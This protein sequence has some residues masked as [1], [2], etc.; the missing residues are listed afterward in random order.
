MG[1]YEVCVGSY[2]ETGRNGVLR[3]ALDTDTLSAEILAA[4]NGA[5]RPSWI[6]HNGKGI[7]YAVSE[8]VPEGSVLALRE[9]HDG[10][11]PL[12]ECPSGGA[13]PCHLCL[14]TS[15]RFLFVSNYTSGSLSMV[16]L[17]DMGAPQGVV[18][19]VQHAGRGT[20]PQRQADAHVH[21]SQLQGDI[22]YVCDLGQDAIFRYRVDREEKRLIA[23]GEPLRM[24]AGSG[25]RHLCFAPGRP[26]RLYAVGEL[27]ASLCYWVLGKTGWTLRQR[28]S[29][30]PDGVPEGNGTAGIHI[31]GDGRYLFVSNRGADCI[32][33]FCLAP[34]GTIRLLDVCAVGGRTPRD[35]VVLDNTLLVACQ[36]DSCLRMLRLNPAD[37]SLH[38]LDW[39]F[40]IDK[41]SCIQKVKD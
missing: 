35:F 18:D 29:T 6:V 9:E 23:W 28:I 15:E 21:F 31:S 36:N 38:A 25:V 5:T 30:L 20:H 8:V 32:T 41:P 19:C 13:A 40:P 34:D 16:E 4:Y 14:D 12:G 10:F 2:A 11:Y 3:L 24:P 27:D 1:R 7:L 26:E 33:V 37:G 39:R 17:D 22:L